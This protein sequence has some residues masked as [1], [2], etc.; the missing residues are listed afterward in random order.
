MA[1]RVSVLLEDD[2][3][4][5][6]ADE[7]VTFGLD[8]QLFEIDLSA[9]NAIKLRKAIAAY[10]TAGR[11]VRRTSVARPSDFPAQRNGQGE[12]VAAIRASARENGYE[13]SSRGRISAI[14][15]AA[16]HSA[17]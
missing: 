8:R 5:G 12:N 13:V 7:T 14:T 17:N 4:G 6:T 10:I 11:R 3:D 1:S 16:Y 15:R 9:K 2:L